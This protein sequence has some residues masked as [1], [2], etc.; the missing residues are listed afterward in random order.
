MT[1][2][3]ETIPDSS[4]PCEYLPRFLNRMLNL[5]CEVVGRFRK[6]LS[7]RPTPLSGVLTGALMLLGAPLAI[8]L[9]HFPIVLGIAVLL[10]CMLCEWEGVFSLGVLSVLAGFVLQIVLMVQIALR[11]R[12]KAAAG[13]VR[14]Y[15]SYL[16]VVGNSVLFIAAFWGL[17]IVA[18]M[19][20]SAMETPED[21]HGSDLL[22]GIVMVILSVFLVAASAAILVH[23][24]WKRNRELG[25]KTVLAV[26]L[27]KYAVTWV[28]WLAVNRIFTAI[29]RILHPVGEKEAMINQHYNRS[30]GAAINADFVR[31][32]TQ[33]TNTAAETAIAG[34]LFWILKVTIDPLVTG[35]PDDE[36]GGFSAAMRDFKAWLSQH[37]VF[38]RYAV[39]STA[40]ITIVGTGFL[41]P[42]LGKMISLASE[43]RYA[44]EQQAGQ[45]QFEE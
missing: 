36:P 29:E 26:F 12:R 42:E 19:I 43:K 37:V 45:A 9:I 44:E 35:R 34:I 27:T 17:F 5:S 41:L 23:S 22:I 3:A 30:M 28:S 39:L 33:V 20:Q 11:V 2:E 7:A 4:A 25:W 24:C 8:L 18:M 1:L 6:A 16:E 10:A 15:N 31:G 38:F 13:E 21:F 32:R 40:V 14:V